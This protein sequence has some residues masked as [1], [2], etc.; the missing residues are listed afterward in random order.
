MATYSFSQERSREALGKMCI[1]DNRPFSVVD[2]KGLRGFAW[3]LNPL[4]KFPSRWTFARDCLSI[5]K[6]EA[7]KLN[8]FFETPNSVSY[9]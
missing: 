8:D 3:E 9:H 4:F 2:D 5:Y 7:K 6:E 1:K